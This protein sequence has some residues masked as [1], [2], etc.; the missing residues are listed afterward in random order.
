MAGAAAGPAPRAVTVE[1]VAQE[2]SR[3]AGKPDAVLAAELRGMRLTERLGTS[4]FEQLSAGLPGEQSKEELRI[5]ADSAAWL[6]SPADAISPKPAPSSAE[7]HQML[8]GL[9][10]Y[11][12]TMQHQLPNFLATRATTAFEDR[13]Q[14]DV[15]D[16]MGTG[17]RGYLPLHPVGWSSSAVAYVDGSETVLKKNAVSKGEGVHGLETAG[18]FGPF[19]R[20]TLAD[21][22]KGRITWA[23]WEADIDGIEAVFDYVV[24][25][26]SSHYVVQFCCTGGDVTGLVASRIYFGK[27]GYHGEIAFDPKNGEIRRITLVADQPPGELVEKAAMVV[28]YGP[29][30]IAGR[31][32]IVPTR[33]IA[34]LG[35][36]ATPPAEGLHMASDL[37]PLKTYLNDT[38][39][40]DYHQFRGELR[41]LPGFVPESK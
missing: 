8:S 35:A 17:S 39:F 41:I 27:P 23:R 6:E 40:E 19:Q 24:P 21:A 36:H 7:L 2:L 37:G 22:T 5:L 25:R 32:V 16:Q 31:T 20:I 12:N 34:L 13:P 4:R 10:D 29:V 26:K 11:V 9:V 14:S 18:E 1:Q 15:V 28:E 30:Q 33:S 3:D 38:V